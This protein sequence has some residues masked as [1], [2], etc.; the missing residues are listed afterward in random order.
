MD[1]S[2]NRYKTFANSPFLS[3]RRQQTTLSSSSVTA[4]S[5]EKHLDYHNIISP[6]LFIKEHTLSIIFLNGCTRV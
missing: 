6:L 4:T 2:N 1:Y 5:V 3:Y